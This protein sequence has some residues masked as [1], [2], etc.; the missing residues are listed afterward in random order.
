[1]KIRNMFTFVLIAALGWA[2]LAAAPENPATDSPPTEAI[3][4]SRASAEDTIDIEGRVESVDQQH[5]SIQIKDKTGNISPVVVG[6]KTEIRRNGK[7]VKLRRL[8]KGDVV[9]VDNAR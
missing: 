2:G 8:R 9:D 7:L 1:M 5:H 3:K 6:P 4:A